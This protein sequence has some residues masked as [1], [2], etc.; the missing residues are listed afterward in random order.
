M[1]VLFDNWLWPDPSE[2]ILMESLGASVSRVRVRGFSRRQTSIWIRA[3]RGGRQLP[4]PTS[5]LPAHMALLDQAVAE[6][7]SEHRHAILLAAIM[8]VARIGLEVDRLIVAARQD[9]T[10]RNS[11]RCCGPKLRQ[12]WT[13]LRWCWTEIARELPTHIAVGADKPPSDLAD[14]RAIGDGRP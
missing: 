10:A 14:A 9:A 11:R 3:G 6:G 1:I 4:P 7:V 5:D 12:Q 8:R 13:R 2:A